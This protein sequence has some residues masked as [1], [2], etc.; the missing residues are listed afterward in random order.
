ME[1]PIF[2]SCECVTDKNLPWAFRPFNEIC[3]L[4]LKLNMKI[5][6]WLSLQLWGQKICTENTKLKHW[7]HLYLISVYFRKRF[8]WNVCKFKLRFDSLLDQSEGNRDSWPDCQLLSVLL[9]RW[10]DPDW[11]WWQDTRD[12]GK[13]KTGWVMVKEQQGRH[14]WD[15]WLLDGIGICVTEYCRLYMDVFLVYIVIQSIM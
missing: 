5:E 6:N 4:R 15:I 11:L 12:L 8:D 2:G 10:K 13:W 3:T 1:A 7:S 9:S 14:S